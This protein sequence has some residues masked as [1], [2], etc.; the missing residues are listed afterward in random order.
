[1]LINI[2]LIYYFLLYCKQLGKTLYRG[3]YQMRNYALCTAFFVSMALNGSEKGSEKQ[4]YPQPNPK[5]KADAQ[6]LQIPNDSKNDFDSF[7][8]SFFIHAKPSTQKPPSPLDIAESSTEYLTPDAVSQLTRVEI[9]DLAKQD[10]LSTVP[11]ISSRLHHLIF[12]NCEL[13]T[14]GIALSPLEFCSFIY[15][16]PLLSLYISTPIKNAKCIAFK[17]EYGCDYVTYINRKSK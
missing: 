3:K 11:N 15:L 6:I 5:H 8:K 13:N 7:L 4:A 10:K 12:N 9:L 17:E 14:I 16:R 2:L 1:M